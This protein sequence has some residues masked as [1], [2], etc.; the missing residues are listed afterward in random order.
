MDVFEEFEKL[1]VS[2]LNPQIIDF[3]DKNKDKIY[4]PDYYMW[5]RPFILDR[6]KSKIIE[7]WRHCIKDTDTL[8]LLIFDLERDF[9]DVWRN[10]VSILTS[11]PENANLLREKASKKLLGKISLCNKI[12][13]ESNNFDISVSQEDGFFHLNW[14]KL[15]WKNYIKAQ[16]SDLQSAFHFLMHQPE[17]MISSAI[18]TVDLCTGELEN[19]YYKVGRMNNLSVYYRVVNEVEKFRETILPITIWLENFIKTHGHPPK[20]SNGSLNMVLL[21]SF[22]GIGYFDKFEGNL[23]SAEKYYQKYLQYAKDANAHIMYAELYIDFGEIKKAETLLEM[24][25]KLEGPDWFMISKAYFHTQK[26]RLSNLIGN[27]EENDIFTA[28]EIIEKHLR[29]N[30]IITS[31]SAIETYLR[32]ADYYLSTSNH[33]NAK[34][35][36]TKVSEMSKIVYYHDFQR[37][38]CLMKLIIIACIEEED[39]ELYRNELFD[40][41]AAYSGHEKMVLYNELA[42]ATILKHTKGMQKGAARFKA[43]DIFGKISRGKIYDINLYFYARFNYCELLLDAY[44]FYGEEEIL[45]N[46][47][48]EVEVIAKISKEKGLVM[49]H[50]EVLILRSKIATLQ[51]DLEASLNYLEE[52]QE[53]AD[54]RNLK[55]Y[56][57]RIKE[58]KEV[59][60]HNLDSWNS[61]RKDDKIEKLKLKQYLK[62][63]QQNITK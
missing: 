22:V 19:S 44:Q 12:L 58:E 45:D 63:A 48:S 61:M 53:I 40:V 60:L 8:H 17:K 50:I 59:Y 37:A 2:G 30:N 18:R 35:Y 15:I 38:E 36:Y 7:E 29:E 34:K 11:P 46:L 28:I 41:V 52:A 14:S 20:L 13:E 9:S 25:Q 5:T 26:A 62:F 47:V 49:Y 57:E 6:L 21:S 39:P 3:M 1:W 54:K 4:P 32:V 42:E 27:T 31:I 10:V 56:Q 33:E 24:S 16:Q 55:T 51:K 43:Q 23:I